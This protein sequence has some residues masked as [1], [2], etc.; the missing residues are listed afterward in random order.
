MGRV[1]LLLHQGRK[2]LGRIE[3]IACCKTVAEEKN[4]LYRFTFR[5]RLLLCSPFIVDLR[6]PACTSKVN[7]K[8]DHR[9]SRYNQ[10]LHH[11]DSVVL[12]PVSFLLPAT[13]SKE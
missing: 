11:V 3:A 2:G 7:N 6:F 8:Q 1:D 4:R 12:L 10:F 9:K 13:R 5:R